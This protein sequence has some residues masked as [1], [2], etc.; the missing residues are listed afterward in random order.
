MAAASRFSCA[1]VSHLG[2]IEKKLLDMGFLFVIISQI[3]PFD[4]ELMKIAFFVIIISASLLH[5][6]VRAR[7]E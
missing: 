7:L 3:S 2:G 1:S 4:D 5:G 6:Q